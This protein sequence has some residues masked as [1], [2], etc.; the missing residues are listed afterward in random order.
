MAKINPEDFF[1]SI[2]QDDFVL[3][4]F[5]YHSIRVM[6]SATLLGKAMGCYD[7][8]LRIAALLHDI[9]KMG[10]SP[11]IL[12]KPSSLSPLEFTIIKAHSHLGNIIIR[13]MLGM[14]RAAT[15]VRDHHER[16]DGR[17]YPRGLKGKKISLQGRIIC[18]CD[19]FDAMTI[20]R[21]IY[22]KRVLSYEEAYE[23]LSRCTGTQF[24]PILVKIFIPL[25]RSLDLP[26]KKDWYEDDE[27]LNEIYLKNMAISGFTTDKICEKD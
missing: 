26:E 11:K 5:K 3:Y 23:E 19:A 2:A 17:G 18:I 10:L 24:D 21:G 8:D 27:L 15:F 14:K 9:G 4:K 20:D 22:N 16:W 6:Y 1:N 25:M 12:L 7:E 13:D